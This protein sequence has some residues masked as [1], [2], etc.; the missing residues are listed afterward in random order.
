MKLCSESIMINH[1]FKIQYI[2]QEY[3]F[4][5]AKNPLGAVYLFISVNSITKN[6]N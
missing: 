3:H 5:G 1:F 2:E 6:K 4:R